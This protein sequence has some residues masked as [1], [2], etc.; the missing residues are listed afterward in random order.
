MSGLEEGDEIELYRHTGDGISC[1]SGEK[2]SLSTAPGISARDITGNPL[3]DGESFY[4]SAKI[5]GPNSSDCVGNLSHAYT[6]PVSQEISVLLVTSQTPNN[7]FHRDPTF[8]ITG[9]S[10][11]EN[12][13]LYTDSSC[14]TSPLISG[15]VPSGK[16]DVTL[17]VNLDSDTP[18]IV[19]AGDG[20]DCS[21][22]PAT[23]TPRAFPTP[24]LSVSS[25]YDVPPQDQ[26]S[27]IK[28]NDVV[29]GFF[30][31]E[32][33]TTQL[34]IPSQNS[35]VFVQLRGAD[36]NDQVICLG[37][38]DSYNIHSTPS[39]ISRASPG[40]SKPF[41]ELRPTITV[42]G[43]TADDVIT[44]FSDSSCS[45]EVQFETTQGESID[46][47]LTQDLD[48]KV[49]HHFSA[50]AS[51]DKDNGPHSECVPGALDYLVVGGIY[52]S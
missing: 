28:N 1:A 32:D 27:G 26:V 15:K 31:D 37:T 17:I 5:T 16:S 19:Y 22:A 33:C 12:I 24:G 47:T 42:S 45:E 13:G 44:L 10:E 7:S 6:R 48:R 23:F 34:V 29:L 21:M 11:E 36:V 25:G 38:Q 40:G 50:M 35:N 8:I 14:M 30:S 51:I 20:T 3:E 49:V 43:T 41:R 4:Y 2:T 39:G 52:L 9:V 46:F 18:L